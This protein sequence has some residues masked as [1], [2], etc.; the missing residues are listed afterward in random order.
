LIAPSPKKQHS[1]VEPVQ[2]TTSAHWLTIP[3]LLFTLAVSAFC[4]YGLLVIWRTSFILEGERYF[5]LLDDAM[6]S[7]RYARNLADG[8]GLVWNPGGE[9]IEGYTNPLWVLYMALWHLLP[10]PSS[11]VSL[12]IQLSSLVFLVTN[13]F[14]VRRIALDISRGS[15]ATALFAV[16]L[17][18]FYFP[19]NS[20]AL[21]GMEVGPLVMLSSAGAHICIKTLR[22]GRF[23]VWAYV[24]LGTGSLVRFDAAVL[25]VATSLF[26]AVLDSSNAR[27]HLAVGLGVT[28]LSGAAQL[29]FR[30][31]YYGDVLPNTFYLK[32]EGFPM[33]HRVR[34]G[35]HVMLV[36]LSSMSWAV[37]LAAFAIVFVRRDRC[38][39]LLTL[40]YFSQVVYSVYI[41]GDTWEGAGS[42]RF[43]SLVMPLFLVLLAYS[44]YYFLRALALRLSY[45]TLSRARRLDPRAFVLLVHLA[46][47]LS[48][49]ALNLQI[50][51]RDT[52][53]EP[54]VWLLIIVGWAAIAVLSVK[55]AARSIATSV[56]Q[57]RSAGSPPIAAPGRARQAARRLVSARRFPAY[58]LAT[59]APLLIICLNSLSTPH[60]ANYWY[61]T[62]ESEVVIAN[63]YMVAG[64][65]AV[66]A[67]SDP[68]AAYAVVWAGI[69]PY[70]ADRNAIDLLGKNDR[71]IAREPWHLPDGPDPW[72]NA[73][74]GH[75]KYNL[76]YSIGR[77]RPDIVVQ[78]WP[79][80]PSDSLPTGAAIPEEAEEYIVHDY[81]RAY[82]GSWVLYLRKDSA[83]IR[84]DNVDRLAR[85]ENVAP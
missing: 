13:L 27:L 76:A 9:R 52:Y 58:A 21:Q 46:I 75:A 79:Y 10:I 38:I 51:A 29:V 4:A 85:I 25:L 44:I 35:L 84:W 33:V 55:F 12:P 57:F 28:L 63:R 81:V 69:L 36:F 24:L 3:N 62:G 54:Q 65:R 50:R 53:L 22:T 2:P 26:M 45:G 1:V 23:S 37:F 60:M 59:V 83:H 67:I 32:V 72:L 74:P 7:M 41:G 61:I 49:V 40:L 39:L 47:F 19:M 14:L 5:S 42:N 70:F 20:W 31:I 77:L 66:A 15:H 11:K 73:W 8:Y 64:A 16:A 17:T 56:H 43:M 71:T 82:I 6:I 34:R 78:M 48:L 18:A 68:E 30:L 80:V